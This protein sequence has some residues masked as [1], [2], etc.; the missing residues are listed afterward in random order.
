MGLFALLKYGLPQ[1]LKLRV[2]ETQRCCMAR[3][4][5]LEYPHSPYMNLAI[6]EAV[7][8]AVGRCKVSETLRFWRNDRTI[9]IGLFQ[10]PSLE[11]NFEECM[12][13]GVRVV[14]RFTGGGAVYHDL[15][16]L[17]FALS[18][19]RDNPAIRERLFK[20][21][22]L[23]GTA[24]EFG[25]KRIGV[26]NVRFKP[27]NSVLIEEHKAVGM[28]SLIT[29]DFVFIHGSMLVNSDIVVLERVLKAS[30]TETN[31]RFVRSKR[32]KVITLKEAL[33][34]GVEISEVKEA[35]IKGLEEVLDVEFIEEEITDYERRFAD[36]LYRKK[37][38]KIEWSLGPCVSCPRRERDEMIFK[39]LTFEDLRQQNHISV[40]SE[41]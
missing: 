7:A 6:E 29:K 16:N 25:L 18:L 11:V 14:R 27:I 2:L 32:Q 33:E 17:N 19:R 5:D 9:V 23:I 30:N 34:D 21:F 15:G 28:A 31:D 26:Q 39:R 4:L 20:G 12:R 8:L 35:I 24:V 1:V 10:C 22:E 36:E 38:S 41:C 37:Y 40:K 3:V 13:Y